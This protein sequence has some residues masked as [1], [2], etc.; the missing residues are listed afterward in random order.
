MTNPEY[1]NHSEKVIVFKNLKTSNHPEKI[2][3]FTFAKLFQTT[4]YD[5]NNKKIITVFR[6]HNANHRFSFSQFKNCI[7]ALKIENFKKHF[8]TKKYILLH[9]IY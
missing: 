6:S 4:K 2:I 3:D 1:N 8:R 5:S 7:K 9:E